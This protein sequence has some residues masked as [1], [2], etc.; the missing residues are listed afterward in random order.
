[1]ILTSDQQPLVLPAQVSVG[2]IGQKLVGSPLLAFLLGPERLKLREELGVIVQV[3]AVAGV[4]P[5]PPSF[6]LCRAG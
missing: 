4:S 5:L 3:V 2:V 1:M 6:S